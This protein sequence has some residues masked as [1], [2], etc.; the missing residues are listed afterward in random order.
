MSNPYK[1]TDPTH[2]SQAAASLTSLP[3][4]EDTKAQMLAMIEQVGHQISAM[5]PSVS[6]TWRH[7]ESRGGCMPPYEQSE[8]QVI[9][10]PSLRFGCADPRTELEA[11]LRHRLSG[12]PWDRSN[13]RHRVPRRAEFSRCPVL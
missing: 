12:C 6:F 3:T 4:L 1:P 5:A 7:E 9:L 11:G 8:G 13:N 2:A 10:L